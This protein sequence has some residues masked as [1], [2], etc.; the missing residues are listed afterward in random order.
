MEQHIRIAVAHQVP[1]VGNVQPPQT[2][3]PARRKPMRVVTNPDP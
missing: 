3:R 1:V 2:K